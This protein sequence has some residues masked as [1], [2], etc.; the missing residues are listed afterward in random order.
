L[1]D[2]SIQEIVAYSTDILIGILRECIKQD[3]TLQICPASEIDATSISINLKNN[4][5]FSN[6]DSVSHEYLSYYS[7]DA[8][9]RFEI[10]STIQ[11]AKFH[12]ENFIIACLASIIICDI[13]GQ[14]KDQWDG[15]VIACSPKVIKIEIL[16]F[17][18]KRKGASNEAFEQ[19]NHTKFFLNRNV[20]KKVKRRKLKN[21]AYLLLS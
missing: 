2:Q 11:R 1:Q 9:R 10:L 8:D 16:E 6:Y 12:K 14:K 17:K 19:L 3:Y 4:R 18:N 20:V 5:R 7:K 13:D 21:G 15:V